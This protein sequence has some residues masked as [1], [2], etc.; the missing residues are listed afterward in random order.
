MIFL[1]TFAKKNKIMTDTGKPEKTVGALLIL[2]LFIAGCSKENPNPKGSVEGTVYTYNPNTPEIQTP[3]EN[4]KIYLLDAYIAMYSPEEGEG[5]P[6]PFLDSTYTD[7]NGFYS[8]TGLEPF[9]YAVLPEKEEHNYS[10]EPPGETWE[11]LLF[12]VTE[13]GEAYS[14]DFKAK[15]PVA[16]N[17]EGKFK[18]H[19][20]SVNYP[21]TDGIFISVTEYETGIKLSRKYS[22]YPWSSQFIDYEHKS[23]DLT[24]IDTFTLEFDYGYYG[25]HSLSN[26]FDITLYWNGE[27]VLYHPEII[28]FDISGCPAE[29]TWQ[30]DWT[31]KEVTRIEK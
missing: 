5:G 28:D 8:F 29:S 1:Q 21:V 17:T 26:T 9:D 23:T 12:T 27:F 10:F 14:I 15:E 6:D 2:I 4:I 19:F 11:S 13:R 7:E 24:E 30:I 3:L 20:K 22:P 31:E 16:E 25:L 18:L